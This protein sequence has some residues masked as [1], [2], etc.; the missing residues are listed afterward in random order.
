MFLLASLFG[1]INVQGGD[2]MSVG[3]NIKALR[4]EKEFTQ[5]RFAKEIG[6]SRSY[7]SDIEN[8]RKNPSSKTLQALSEKLDVTMLYLTT[9]KKAVSD[10]TSGKLK[11][12][13]KDELKQLIDVEL[14]FLEARY[15]EY[16]L[17]FLKISDTQDIIGIT[18]II[19]SLIKSI[20]YKNANNTD[21]DELN[22]FLKN[23]L[24]DITNLLHDYFFNDN[25]A[26]D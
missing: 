16:V 20:E 15:L 18:S 23:E 12:H 21:K 24:D 2:N 10:L 22:E 13:L 5:E 17:H 1:I 7:L 6:I 14:H 26:G 11:S 25:K 4:M 19:E 8:N 3:D 9:G